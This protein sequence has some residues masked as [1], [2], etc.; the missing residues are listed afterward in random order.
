M[1]VFVKMNAYTWKKVC[2][3]FAKG[4]NFYSQEVASQIFQ[5]FQKWGLL[6]KERICSQGSKFFLLRIVPNEKDDKYFHVRFVSLDMYL[7]HS[8]PFL[9]CWHLNCV[10]FL[11]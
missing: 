11:H 5:I 7:I 8:S 1:L 2:H 9:D 4:D 6:L 3:H 10:L